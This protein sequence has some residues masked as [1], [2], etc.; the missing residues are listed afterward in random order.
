MYPCKGKSTEAVLEESEN[1]NM[2]DWIP[3]N[4][5]EVQTK[6]GSILRFSF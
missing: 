2:I 4:V 5:M 1:T 3:F 6:S